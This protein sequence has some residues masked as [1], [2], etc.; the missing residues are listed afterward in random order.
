MDDKQR[1]DEE[2]VEDEDAGEVAGKIF[3]EESDADEVVRCEV[4]GKV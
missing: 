1:L 3:V 4:E 2:R